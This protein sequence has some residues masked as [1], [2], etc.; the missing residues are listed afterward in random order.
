MILKKRGKGKTDENCYF[1]LSYFFFIELHLFP[2]FS[3]AVVIFS[4]F[5]SS[6]E[7]LFGAETMAGLFYFYFFTLTFVA[8]DASNQY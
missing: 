7:F 8:A 3:R 4:F 5:A 1:Q 2:H 6:V